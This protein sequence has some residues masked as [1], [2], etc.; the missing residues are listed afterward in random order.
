[1]DN[2]AIQD[3]KDLILDSTVS[4]SDN[5]NFHQGDNYYNIQNAAFSEINLNPD[6]ECDYPEP[7]FTDMLL[8]HFKHQKLLILGGNFEFDKS[9]FAHYLAWKLKQIHTDYKV[10]R[11][12]DK[13]EDSKIFTSIAEEKEPSILLFNQITPHDVNYDIRRLNQLCIT[14]NHYLIITTDLPK[15]SWKFPEDIMKNF[16]SEIPD[17]GIYANEVLENFLL[18]EFRDNKKKYSFLIDQSD[19]DRNTRFVG[20]HSVFSVVFQLKTIEKIRIF[21]GYLHT[22]TGTISEKKV[23]QLI[24]KIT[25]NKIDIISKW[26]QT[27]T[28]KDKEV[29]LALSIFDGLYDDQFFSATESLVNHAWKVRDTK[30]LSLDYTDLDRLLGFFNIQNLNASTKIILSR[31]PNQRQDFLRTIWF[32][33]RRQLLTALPVLERLILESTDNKNRNWE[34]YG[35]ARRREKVQN[36]ISETLS[37]IG[38]IHLPAV[39]NT[40]LTLAANDNSQIQLVTA[41][42]LA[43]WKAF[44]KEKQLFDTLGRWQRDNAFR[45]FI[46]LIRSQFTGKKEIEAANSPIDYIKSTIALTLAFASNY[47]SPNQLSDQFLA[48]L[49]ELIDDDSPLVKQRMSDTTIPH[50]IQHHLEQLEPILFKMLRKKRYR[51]AVSIGMADAYQVYPKVVEGVITK[52]LAYCEKNKNKISHGD[53]ISFRDRVVMTIIQTLARIKYEDKNSLNANKAYEIIRELQERDNY[54]PINEHYLKFVKQQLIT[55][56]SS[57]NKDILKVISKLDFSVRPELI[58]VLVDLYLK[59]RLVLDGNEKVFKFEK[60][61][62]PVWIKKERPLTEIEKILVAWLQED[63]PIGQEIAMDTLIEY[64][65]KIENPEKEAIE[66][67]L[68]KKS[69]DKVEPAEPKIQPERVEPIKQIKP[70]TWSKVMAIITLRNYEPNLKRSIKNL[71]PILVSQKNMKPVYLTNVAD[72]LDREYADDSVASGLSGY[73]RGF[74]KLFL[75]VK[76]GIVVVGIVLIFI[77]LQMC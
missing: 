27:L 56:A 73:L 47:D 7:N 70:S 34:L 33:H 71:L 54:V 45:K 21:C 31:F 8:D 63:N 19:I 10:L 41:K 60:Y 24:E 42:A 65:E 11:W 37:D 40:L 76:I 23:G 55:H 6:E 15:H 48:I 35:T 61:Y 50:L 49:K 29:S 25:N 26:F 16:W 62:L 75:N 67:Y 43:R 14:N 58:D 4:V 39:E 13:A 9:S 44:E 1:M 38:I 46:K 77:L 52:W 5:S 20:K 30:L 53:Y 69:E 72:K 3:S 12:I 64:A 74:T 51:K 57:I 17:N 18:R 22:E 28:I 2:I 32:S 68:Q 59:Q 36:V 66:N